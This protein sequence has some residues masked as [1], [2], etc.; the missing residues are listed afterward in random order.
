MKVN[1]N[2]PFESA[3]VEHDY[4]YYKGEGGYEAR[5]MV[6]NKLRSDIIN[7]A[8]S[9]WQEITE[10][11]PLKTKEEVIFAFEKIAEMIYRGVRI[12]GSPC[13]G[14]PYAWGFGY[15]SGVCVV[16]KTP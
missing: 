6:D 11:T 4:L 5:L 12:G 14:Q 10:K 9:N 7:Y 15:N 16:E 8:I 3:C 1:K 13:T 2:I